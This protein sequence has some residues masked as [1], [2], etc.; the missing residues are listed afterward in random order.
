LQQP[1]IAAHRTFGAETTHDLALVALC[2]LGHLARAAFIPEPGRTRRA[3]LLVPPNIR[4]RKSTV[5]AFGI[6]G[7]HRSGGLLLHNKNSHKPSSVSVS[8]KPPLQSLPRIA[9]AARGPKPS[10]RPDVVKASEGHFPQHHLSPN[11]CHDVGLI[12]AD[13]CLLHEGFLLYDNV[14]PGCAEY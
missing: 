12:M 4:R 6:E 14:S 2:L 7:Q 1:R 10:A 5:C 13:V 3:T 9:E 8:I 11:F